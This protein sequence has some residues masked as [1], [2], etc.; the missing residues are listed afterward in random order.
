M[1]R[2]PY[3]EKNLIL[4]L[5]SILQLYL[6]LRV[7]AIVSSSSEPSLEQQQ[8]IS[9][10]QQSPPSRGSQLVV[11]R[12]YSPKYF[13]EMELKEGETIAFMDELEV[14][15]WRG[16]KLGSSTQ[17]NGKSLLIFSL[18]FVQ[19]ASNYTSLSKYFSYIGWCVS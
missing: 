14:G 11:S 8:P 16:M 2:V 13:D 6:S 4:V 3:H 9:V 17:V 5:P 15:W 1:K 18:N 7:V 12:S 19:K 10:T